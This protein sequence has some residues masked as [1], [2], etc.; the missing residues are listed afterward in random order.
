M[1]TIK[2]V[3]LGIF[4][5]ALLFTTKTFAQEEEKTEEEFEPVY[6]TITTGHWSSDAETDFSDWKET[7]IEYFNKVTS[8]ND[9]I[10]GSGYYTH[11]LTDDSSE[12]IFVS[13]YKSWEDIQAANE[14]T[15]KL[16]EE[17]WPDEDERD[18][19]F[20]KQNSYY[21]P[22]HSDEIYTS[23][24]LHKP[25]NTDSTEPLL[26]YVRKNI[27]SF[28]GDRDKF[29]AYFDNVLMKNDF[30]KGIWIHRH[31]WGSD[32]RE[33]QV[34]QA[35]E[36][37]GD[38]DKAWEENQRLMKEYIPDEDE[39]AVFWKEFRKLFDGHSDAI[40]ENIPELSK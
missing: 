27:L 7:E 28:D 14:V 40:Y 12:I 35:Y 21:G 32:S 1:K 17:G 5:F 20:E 33:L 8:K 29:K 13:V 2:K 15:N 22:L 11:M 23:T 31:R 10:I 34:V 37:L 38:F 18:A 9:L 16:I 19:F 24:S 30:I 25:L 39:R 36:S 26:F 4:V 6:L 3:F